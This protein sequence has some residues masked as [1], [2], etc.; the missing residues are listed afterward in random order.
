MAA[1]WDQGDLTMDGAWRDLDCSAI[2]PA[3]AQIIKFKVYGED[4]TEDTK[5]YLRKNGA[6]NG[7]AVYGIWSQAA[8]QGLVNNF[9][10]PCDTDRVVE[11][12]ANQAW[13]ALRITI[14]GWE[15]YIE[16]VETQVEIDLDALEARVTVNEGDIDGAEGDIDTLE[17]EMD[18]VEARVTINEGNIAGLSTASRRVLNVYDETVTADEMVVINGRWVKI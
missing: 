10:V 2:V 3:G 17:T 11:Y 5:L 8:N 6:T 13:L 18:A 12:N 4:D 1:D 15:G 7:V 16:D 9:D 14:C